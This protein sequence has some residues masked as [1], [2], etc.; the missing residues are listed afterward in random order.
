MAENC[1]KSE[2]ELGNWSKNRSQDRELKCSHYPVK[3]MLRSMS[4]RERSSGL[5]SKVSTWLS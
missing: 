5:G 2:E 3:S 1:D 4:T